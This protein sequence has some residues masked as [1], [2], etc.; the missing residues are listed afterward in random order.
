MSWKVTDFLNNDLAAYA[1]YDNVRKLPSYIDGMKM[2]QRKVVYT[3]LKKYPKEFIKTETL[4]NIT[5]AFTNYLHGANNIATAVCTTMTQDFVGAN[6]FPL[7][8]GNSGGWGC[9]I[10]P[11]AAA[12]R[13][14]RIK[15]SDVTKAIIHQ[16][17]EEI[18]GRQF[19][20]GDFIEPKFFVPTFPALFLNGSLGLST[21]FSATIHPRNPKDVLDYI[22]KRLEEKDVKKIK[23]LPWFKGFKGEVRYNNDTQ[24]AES[25]GVVKKVKTNLYEIHELPIGIDYQRYLSVLDKLCDDKV[26]KDY[27]D[28]CEPKTDTILFKVKVE[29]KFAK[30]HSSEEKLLKVFKLVKTLPETLNCI[31]ENNRVREF[32]NVQE[33]LDAFIKIRLE[34]YQKRKEYLIQKYSNQMT[35]LKSKYAFCAAVIKETVK[36][37]KTSKAVIEKQLEEVKYVVRQNGSFD[38]LL[39]MPI[40]SISQEKMN[41]LKEKLI[42]LSNI[43][44]E[45][46]EK[47]AQNM[48]LSDM[49]ELNILGK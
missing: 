47:T 6:N 18:I 42:D 25:V 29:A 31:D 33:I 22:K 16:D 17:D 32:T 30:E 43:L 2:S 21:G 45:T 34:Y 28:C 37:A 8:T 10:N 15:L 14:T 23:L 12:P 9:R 13:Y 26:I 19:F 20:E 35:I 39:N 1:S 46:R 36:V 44:K 41:E 38:Y 5:A 11:T 49:K 4:A 3:L 24:V 40:G 27:D 48:W 7:T